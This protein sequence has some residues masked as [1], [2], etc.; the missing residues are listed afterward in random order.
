MCPI[1][2][3]ELNELARSLPYAHHTK[4]SVENDPVVLPNGRIY[5]RERLMRAVAKRGLEEGQIK[6]PT[7]G[8]IFGEDEVRK[9]YIT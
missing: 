6:D 5:G 7:T 8:E 1:C 2:S 4:S 9:V 3:T